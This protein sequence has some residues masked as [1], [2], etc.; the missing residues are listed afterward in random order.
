[1]R[2]RRKERLEELER[3]LRRA[4]AEADGLRREVRML[5][6][7]LDALPVGVIA[8][9]ERGAE[10]LRNARAKSPVGDMHVDAL[11][12]RQVAGL[13]DAGPTEHGREAVEVTGPPSFSVEVTV[14][15]LPSGG[16]VAVVED[17]T[18]RR[19]VD[20]IRR[21]FAVNVSHELRTPVGALAVLMEALEGETDQADTAKLMG[22]MAAEIARAQ[23]LIE[24][25]LDLSRIEAAAERPHQ[26][27][28]SAEVVAA[29]V[30]REQA[31]SEKTGVGIETGPVADVR[32]PG[33]FEELVY[34]V[35]NLVDNAVKYSDEG[36]TVVV[37]AEARDGE[38]AFVVRDHGM[39]IP[40][41]DLD[42]VFE[43]FFR[44]DRARDRRTG[45]S[46]LGLAIVRHVAANHGGEVSVASTEGVG[47]VFTLR[48][49]AP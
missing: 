47:S 31:Q 49:A 15:P 37:S 21:D 9:D 45:G 38:V 7:A 2:T 36:S 34:A 3:A 39:G 13:L 40:A 28:S 33:D 5:R 27:V 48:V 42:R 29:A 20:A 32:F 14:D 1:M 26:P 30:A 17:V 46:G 8:R 6:E 41:R 22:R 12:G 23:Q 25:L 4:G 44:V 24:D 11:V 18:E 19:R 35:A 43:R 16:V 10:V